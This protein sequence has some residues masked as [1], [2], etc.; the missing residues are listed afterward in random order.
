MTTNIISSIE[1]EALSKLYTIEKPDEVLAFLKENAFLV[2]TLLEAPAQ[3]HTYF[4]GSEL[5]LI[6]FY[7]PE[8][9]ENTHVT[10]WIGSKLEP[11]AALD[12]LDELDK[13]WSLNLP[14]Q[15]MK[16]L[17]TNLVSL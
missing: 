8:S 17:S 4:P 6:V 15:V 14:A 1:I 13:V 12:K 2:P 11:A 9:P 5:F 3:I 7:V 10:V 16:K